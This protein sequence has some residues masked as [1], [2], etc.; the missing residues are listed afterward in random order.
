MVADSDS[1]RRGIDHRARG[2]QLITVG[3]VDLP[4]VLSSARVTIAGQT[5]GKPR[6]N[7]GV[8]P[9]TAT[10]SRQTVVLSPSLGIA[11]R[12]SLGI[13]LVSDLDAVS[14]TGSADP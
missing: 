8:A 10:H 14:P 5:R 2:G 3:T 4:A 12:D 11:C 9:K 13:R 6:P 1:C 7:H